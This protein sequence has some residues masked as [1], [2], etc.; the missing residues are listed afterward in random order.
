MRDDRLPRHACVVVDEPTGR[1][2]EMDVLLGPIETA[3]VFGLQ[4]YTFAARPG[5]VMEPWVRVAQRDDWM[6]SA[7]I[8]VSKRDDD[9][10]A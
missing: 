4:Q 9:D 2:D 10:S 1:V 8:E 7:G 3:I 5:Y 6:L